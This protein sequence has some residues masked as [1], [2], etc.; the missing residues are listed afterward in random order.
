MC[1]ARLLSC[2]ACRSVRRIF[3]LSEDP[4]S[5]RFVRQGCPLHLPSF[6]VSCL[7]ALELPLKVAV[8][9]NRRSKLSSSAMSADHGIF[10]GLS[11]LIL[12]KD[13]DWPLE[14]V[15]GAIR[16]NGG[17]ITA[18][19]APFTH[20]VLSSSLWY[21]RSSFHRSLAIW[22]TRPHDQD[23]PRRR[24]RRHVADGYRVPERGK[25]AR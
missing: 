20:V 17:W 15:K 6:C 19:E 11:F 25:T 16:A 14:Q 24:S 18:G 22:L 9:T 23:R 7:A 12:D 2:R 1:C 13:L 4:R 8:S 3:G 10:A 21:A 5:D